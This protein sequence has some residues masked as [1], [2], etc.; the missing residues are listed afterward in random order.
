[1]TYDQEIE[2][3]LEYARAGL[4]DGSPF[5]VD[6]LIWEVER[7]ANFFR[8][9]F[10]EV[11]FDVVRLA[12]KYG[13]SPKL[14]GPL[15]GIRWWQRQAAEAMLQGARTYDHDGTLECWSISDSSRLYF[16]FVE[17]VNTF[18]TE[19]VASNEGRTECW[20][21]LL[22]ARRDEDVPAPEKVV[23][24]DVVQANYFM[25]LAWREDVCPIGDVAASIRRRSNILSL[26]EDREVFRSFAVPLSSRA[27]FESSC[28]EAFKPCSWH[29]VMLGEQAGT[30][31]AV[32]PDFG[33]DNYPDAPVQ[34]M[35]YAG[36][37]RQGEFAN[38]NEIFSLNF[39]PDL[40]VGDDA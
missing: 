24:F 40:G 8:C 35:M 6:A 12:K 21:N 30:P 9:T 20:G 15:M 38:L 7:I 26:Q 3:A 4:K 32:L 33:I 39:L 28:I 23:W 10:Q 34:N 18:N 14:V 25:R 29:L 27:E 36:A 16:A 11:A 17:D 2:I 31:V 22:S 19:F 1:M 5:E 13:L 37:C